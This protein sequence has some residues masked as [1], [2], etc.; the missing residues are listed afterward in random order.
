MPRLWLFM[1]AV[2]SSL[3]HKVLHRGGGGGGLV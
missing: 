3:I 1:D 2:D